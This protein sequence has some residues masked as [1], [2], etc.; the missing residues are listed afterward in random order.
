M[1][2]AGRSQWVL[3]ER[4]DTGI[5]ISK[6]TFNQVARLFGMRLLPIPLEGNL[7]IYHVSAFTGVLCSTGSA[8]S[9]NHLSSK[10]MPVLHAANSEPTHRHI[11]PI[12]RVF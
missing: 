4:Y 9:F 10:S 11:A 2:C 1:H 7:H 8:R 3:P 6:A 5:C 12:G